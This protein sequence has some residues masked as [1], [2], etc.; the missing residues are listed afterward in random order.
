M[1]FKDMIARRRPSSDPQPMEAAASVPEPQA[2]TPEDVVNAQRFLDEDLE[3]A[4]GAVGFVPA[5]ARPQIKDQPNWALAADELEFETRAKPAPQA[6][7]DAGE[8]AE[9]PASA[10]P[11]PKIWNAGVDTP[12][13]Q[14]PFTS[15][16]RPTSRPLSPPPDVM[17]APEPTPM[18]RV[19][20]ERVKTRLLGFHSEPEAVDPFDSAPEQATAAPM[21]PVGWLVVVEG[22][23]R[24]AAFTLTAGLST[25]GR[26]ADQTVCLDYGDTS[27]SRERHA[28]VAYDEED[29]RVYV[30]HG[31][32]SNLV[33]LNG[34]PLLSTEE[35]N[36]GDTLK[37]GKT[38]LTYVGFC[39]P[40]FSW[41]AEADGEA[42]D[43]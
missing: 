29:K 14:S 28:S 32:K 22:P 13:A 1:R 42:P 26:D 31:G 10:S 43:A 27:I 19:P 25:I 2:V 17:P 30:G 3:R 24:G 5:P 16:A 9:G 23:G 6:V 38:V 4:K 35:L 39:S 41:H 18:R 36:D 15:E 34:K 7:P 20:S 33:R 21:F 8:G 12:L 40:E 11:A 37:I